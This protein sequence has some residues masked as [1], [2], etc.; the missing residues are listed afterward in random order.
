[1][2]LPEYVKNLKM[3]IY[4]P[5][6][7]QKSQNVFAR[8]CQKSQIVSTFVKISKLLLNYN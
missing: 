7:C 5:P 8:K 1:M 3:F 4:F 6:I 2:F